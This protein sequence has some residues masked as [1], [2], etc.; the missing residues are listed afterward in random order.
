MYDNQQHFRQNVDL[1]K[2]LCW[3][4]FTEKLSVANESEMYGAGALQVFLLIGLYHTVPAYR[5]VYSL[6]TVL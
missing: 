2:K 6:F 3:S 4:I 1:L 5:A